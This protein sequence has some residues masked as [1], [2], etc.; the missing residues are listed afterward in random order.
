MITIVVAVSSNFAI[1]KDNSLLW[2]LPNDLKSFR[3]ITIGGTVVMGRKTFES[4]GRP[5]PG[6]R[7][8]VVTRDG[9]YCRDGIE[10]ANTFNEAMEK[11]EWDCFVI[12]G[13]QIYEVALPLAGCMY[14]TH[15]DG[16]FEADSYFPRFGTEWCKVDERTFGVDEFNQYAHSIVRYERCEF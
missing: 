1:G 13:S 6:R 4:I 7:N 9:F 3:N 14:V 16:E 12:G 10:V 11:A 2:Q 8:I 15:V 5:L